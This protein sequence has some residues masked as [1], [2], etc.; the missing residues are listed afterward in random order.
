[1]EQRTQGT[2][3]DEIIDLNAGAR[4]I[5]RRSADR[6]FKEI[7]EAADLALTAEA[8][9]PQRTEAVEAPAVTKIEHDG[10]ELSSLSMFVRNSNERTLFTFI[11]L[12]G[13]P[14]L[15]ITMRDQT[16]DLILNNDQVKLLLRQMTLWL[17]R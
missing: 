1:M 13:Y 7:L 2:E 11:E 14:I 12:E 10:T 8:P 9:E 6:P 15:R 3:I 5:P 17:T 4:A 16:N